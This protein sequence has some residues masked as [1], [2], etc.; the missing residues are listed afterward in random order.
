MAHTNAKNARPHNVEPGMNSKANRMPN[1][2]E[3]MVAPVVGETNLF[4]HS[5]C[6]IKPAT[7]M[8]TPVQR[9]ASRRGNLEMR[10]IS[11][12]SAF[13][14]SRLAGSISST[15]INSDQTDKMTRT[16]K[17]KIVERW[18]LIGYRPFLVFFG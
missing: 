2:A 1:W 12:C 11:I 14:L 8:P 5:C 4:M 13:P 10:K 16:T 7:L 9:M 17:R 18:F 3:E 15:P 6:M